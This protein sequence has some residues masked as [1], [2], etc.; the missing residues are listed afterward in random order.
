MADPNEAGVPVSA[1]SLPRTQP[2]ISSKDSDHD[3]VTSVQTEDIRLETEKRMKEEA[4]RR[5][6]EK[7]LKKAE[8]SDLAREHFHSHA[9]IIYVS[10]DL[11]TKLRPVAGPC[12][13]YVALENLEKASAE[14]GQSSGYL[15]DKGPP[16]WQNTTTSP[17]PR[18]CI[19]NR[20]LHRDMNTICG[21]KGDSFLF[22]PMQAAPF[23]GMIPFEKAFRQRHLQAEE[24]FSELAMETPTHR[25][26]M[27]QELDWVPESQLYEKYPIVSVDPMDEDDKVAEARI[28]RDG[29]RALIHLLDHELD[30]LVQDHRLIEAGTV[31]KLPFFHLWH[32]FK[33]GQEIVTNDTKPQAYRVLQVTG[34]RK[35]IT[36][37][38]D[39]VSGATQRRTISNLVIDCFH[40]DF[41]GQE[42]GPSPV[43][44]T[45]KPYQGSKAIRQLAAYPLA[46]AAE[47]HLSQIL[48]ERGR[49]FE[50]LVEASH[51]KYNGLSLLGKEPFDTLE[52]ASPS[53][54]LMLALYPDFIADRWGRHGG[55][56]TCLSK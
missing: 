1:G 2:P 38:T 6:A 35:L 33:P 52:E 40:L 25:D 5:E 7:K 32:L 8:L 41:D 14:P 45:I 43:T 47:P 16:K 28:L 31:E 37:S 22:N 27:R 19:M 12:H 51:R 36:R 54:L 29:Y 53:R 42:F 10:E 30:S 49:K 46:L 13:L 26:V 48:T 11:W 21:F 9:G 15:R 56:Q 18:A 44:I 20:I 24:K 3:V 17:P 50:G 4:A 55:F 34:G 39:K 23:R